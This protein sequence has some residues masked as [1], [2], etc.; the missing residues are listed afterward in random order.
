MHIKHNIVFKLTI[1]ACGEGKGMGRLYALHAVIRRNMDFIC[2]H[3][4]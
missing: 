4:Q 3:I 1:V 2:T